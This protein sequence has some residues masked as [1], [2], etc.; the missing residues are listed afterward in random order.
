ME[1]LWPSLD[2][3]NGLNAAYGDSILGVLQGVYLRLRRLSNICTKPSSL[4][5]L[6]VH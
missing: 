5:F 1:L 3:T 2:A 4:D 6:D